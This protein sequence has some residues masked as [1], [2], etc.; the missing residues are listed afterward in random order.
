M[1]R[2]FGAEQIRSVPLWVGR[3]ALLM[4]LKA[5]LLAGRKVLALCG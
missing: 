3:D 5:D 4:D 1:G 2:L